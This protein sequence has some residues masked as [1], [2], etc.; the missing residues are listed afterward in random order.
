MSV[1]ARLFDNTAGTAV[2]EYAAV[3]L[4]LAIG[5]ALVISHVITGT[6]LR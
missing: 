4:T 2:A 3:A 1:L 5:A 6:P